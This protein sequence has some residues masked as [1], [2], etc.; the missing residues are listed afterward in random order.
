MV[1]KVVFFVF[2]LLV[3]E[4]FADDATEIMN[5]GEELSD[6]YL[7]EGDCIQA[8]SKLN[9][10]MSVLFFISYVRECVYCSQ[11]PF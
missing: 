4:G 1:V 9:K 5:K 7:N 10:D 6:K 2:A 8:L 11:R 3:V